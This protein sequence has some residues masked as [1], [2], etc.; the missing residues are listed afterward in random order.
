VLDGLPPPINYR[1]VEPPPELAPTN[2][3]PA[4][5]TFRVPIGPDGSLSNVITTSDAQVSLIFPE[6]SFAPA[7]GQRSVRV[8]VEPLAATAVDPADDPSRIVGNVYALEAAYLPSEDPAPLTPGAEARVVLIYPLT[9]GDHGTHGVLVSPSG[10]T[11]EAVESTD[12][13]G[14]Q[15]TDGPIDGLGYVAVAS[16]AVSA[17]DAPTVGPTEES[18]GSN[19]ATVIIVACLVL[20]VAGL[21]WLFFG[22]RSSRRPRGSARGSRPGSRSRYR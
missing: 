1:W 3:P 6:G 4:T 11:W 13:T 8:T 2:E 16:T 22:G 20:L 15:Q 14:I 9:F 21:G 12:F 7:E 17:T 19:T 10:R 18:R 5:E